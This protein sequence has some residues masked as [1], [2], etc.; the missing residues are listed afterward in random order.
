MA[1]GIEH[2]GTGQF[3]RHGDAMHSDIMA[4]GPLEAGGIP[5]VDDLPVSARDPGEPPVRPPGRD[6]PRAIPVHDEYPGHEPLAV[7]TAA[8]TRPASIHRERAVAVGHRPAE[9]RE[10]PG[11]ADVG[12]P[13]QQFGR[14]AGVQPGHERGA[15]ADQ[16]CPS[17]RSVSVAK[18]LDDLEDRDRI[19]FPPPESGGKR[20]PKQACLFDFGRQVRWHGS[21]CLS[22]GRTRP[23][24]RCKSVGSREQLLAP[25]TPANAT[26]KITL[27]VHRRGT[28][29]VAAP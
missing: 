25:V 24:F 12:I 3:L 20:Q 23:E 15:T 22:L 11:G 7:R 27:S 21:V 14:D 28:E 4:A 2:R 13:A 16:C 10:H 8:V 19:R 17:S 9:R 29:P 18:L 1:R 6:D 26:H 5:V